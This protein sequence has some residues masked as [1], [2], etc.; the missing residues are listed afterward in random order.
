MPT[1]TAC[2]I[3]RD[4]EENLDAC[5]ETL[6]PHVDEV[7]VLDTGSRDRTLAIARAHGA[8]VGEF[9]WSED[10]A[11]ARNAALELAT[12]D[13]VLSVDADELLD[14]ESAGGLRERLEAEPAEA[15]LVW[16]DSLDGGR[17]RQGRPTF[18]SVGVPR[19]FRRRPEIRWERPLHESVA[20]SL[21]RL[22]AGSLEHSGLRLVHHGYLPEVVRARGKHERNRRIL[23][24]HL[25]REPGDHYARYK[26]AAALAAAGEEAPALRELER[27]REAAARLA[28]GPRTRL[29][30]LP[31]AAS[32]EV[33]L[34]RRAGRLGEAAR[35]AEAGLDEWPGVGELAYEAAEVERSCGELEAAAGHYA[36]AL[37]SEPWTDLYAGRPAVRGAASWLGLARVALLAGDPALAL[38]HALRAHGLAPADREARALVARLRLLSGDPDGAWAELEGLLDEAP[39][40]PHVLLLAGEMAWARGEPETAAGLWSAVPEGGDGAGSAAR[41]WR[42]LV[43]LARGDLESAREELR[44]LPAS[45]LPEAGMRALAAATLGEPL[46]VDP[47][48][49]PEALAGE[50]EAWR[51]E[52]LRVSGGGASAL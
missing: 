2:L 10:F 8:R 17:D 50:V 27:L 41:A 47:R 21:E 33:R 36:A 46:E 22:G 32:E 52:L 16:I 12:G 38:D 34:L 29:G 37:E 11:A 40:D 39:G 25:E 6:L 30:F 19:L 35:L 43:A 14:P 1:L 23:A 31:L 48:V 7:V 3:V 5:L 26:L 24:A 9:A 18:R 42:V 4:E 49:R 44:A 28:R 20:P 15:L 45:D 51:G 13:W